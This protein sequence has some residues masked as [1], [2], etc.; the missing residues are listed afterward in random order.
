MKKNY[1]SVRLQLV[2]FIPEFGILAGSQT[3][4]DMEVSE[5]SVEGFTDGF[6]DQGGFET[7]NFD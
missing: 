4:I 2:G 6:A 1:D 5:V 3:N 7:I